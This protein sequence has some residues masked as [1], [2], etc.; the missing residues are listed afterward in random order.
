MAG[1][2][3]DNPAT[4]ETVVEEEFLAAGRIP[5]L[6]TR[7]SAAARDWA[8]ADLDRRVDLCDAMLE[9][10]KA[11]TDRITREITLQMG[12]PLAEAGAELR[13]MEHRARFMMEAAAAQLERYPLADQGDT[14]RF[15]DR[16]PVGVVLDI[17][18]WNYPLLIAVNV[19]VPALL[20]GNAVILKH[21]SRTPLCGR[22]FERAFAEAGAPPGLV[23]AVTATHETSSSLIAHEEIGYVAFTG[24]VEGG[25]EVSRAA[26]GRFIDIGLE[27]GGKDA[28]Y[29]RADADV[30]AAAAAIAEGA[31][32]NAGQSCCAVERVYVDRR[33]YA[34]FLD[35]LVEQAK[36][37]TVGDP[38]LE[39]TKLGPMAKPGA[40]EAVGRQVEEAV[41]AGAR[42]LAGG[43][44][45]QVE[46]R[47]RY[48]EAT[49]LADTNHSMAVMTEESF[50]PVAALSAVD[51]DEE[52]V[53]SVN[54]SRYGLTASIWTSDEK[55][56][57]AL[58]HRLEVGTVF[59]NRC[60]HLD[61]A[62]PWAGRK[63]SGVGLTMSHLGF[64]R[65]VRT[66]GF[67]LRRKA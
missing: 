48:F 41:A 25:R 49:V 42:L 10:F 57:E 18:A 54:D 50:A 20:A 14:R 21:S 1:L 58:G 59:M 26:A 47:G 29:V 53:A 4:G 63:D 46:G 65:M 56:A 19:V 61:P 62:L 60:D 35:A 64:D 66:R 12:K 23:Q 7:A 39:G 33:L 2:R 5:A 9:R 30:E 8:D 17:A 37:W 6:M 67:N 11:D 31:F 45:V 22:A 52:A 55:A 43:R 32:Y 24:S 44:P 36:L 15:I 34:G 40:A 51:G 16:V 13:T 3:V 27:L 28:A 38:L